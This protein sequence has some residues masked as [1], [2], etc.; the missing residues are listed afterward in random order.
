MVNWWDRW[1]ELVPGWFSLMEGR[2]LY[3]QALSLPKSAKIVEIGSFKGRSSLCLLKACQDGNKDEKCVYL[4]DNFSGGSNSSTG[5]VDDRVKV[6][7]KDAL[8]KTLAA[9]DL[10][11]WLN[12][13]ITESSLDWFSR[14]TDFK[15]DLFFIDGGLINIEADCLEA[16]KRLNENGILLCHDYNPNLSESLVV[17]KIDGLGLGGAH[18]GVT[19]TAIYKAVKKG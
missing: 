1:N 19:G 10:T 9:W 4:I 5:F 17:K 3:E 16:W 11:R 13:I 12:E 15:A 7:G 6:S 14:N 8:Q 18:C 2:Y